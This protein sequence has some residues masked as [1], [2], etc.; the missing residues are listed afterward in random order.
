MFPKNTTGEFRLRK[1]PPYKKAPPSNSPDLFARGGF[2]S[3]SF[4][5]VFFYIGNF[6]RRRK[7]IQDLVSDLKENLLKI[8]FLVLKTSKFFAC[9]ADL[10]LLLDQISGIPRASPLVGQRSKTGGKAPKV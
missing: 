3:R 1:P 8:A 5:V 6:R 10:P 9:G 2:L 4:F 7:K